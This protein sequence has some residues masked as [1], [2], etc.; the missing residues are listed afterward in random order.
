MIVLLMSLASAYLLGSIPPSY[1]LGR[2]LKGID[3]RQ[4]G[5]GNVGATNAFRV[6]GKGPGITTL[7]LDVGKGFIAIRALSAFFES[8]FAI[9]IDPLFYQILMGL[10][11]VVGHN[12]TVFLKFKGGKGVATSCGVFLALAPLT[13]FWAASVWAVVALISRNIGFGSMVGALTLPLIMIFL[14]KPPTLILFGALM[15]I[16]I[17]YTHKS[18]IKKINF[19]GSHNR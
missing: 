2:L 17:F 11:V 14:R 8:R 19:K 18:N 6:L 1:L 10:A 3:L 7:L 5:S 12:W 13:L 15:A 9:P 4:H 16:S